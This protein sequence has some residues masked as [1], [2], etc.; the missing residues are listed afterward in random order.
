MMLAASP[1]EFR[2][3]EVVLEAISNYFAACTKEFETELYPFLDLI[4]S[5][6]SI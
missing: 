1:F 2:A 5:K 4:A 3:L 6:V